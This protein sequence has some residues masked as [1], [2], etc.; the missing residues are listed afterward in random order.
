MQT[1]SPHVLLRVDS[2]GVQ[3]SSPA[4]HRHAQGIHCQQPQCQPAARDAVQG[5]G[6]E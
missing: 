3:V 1:V 5:G 2:D 4:D 6:H